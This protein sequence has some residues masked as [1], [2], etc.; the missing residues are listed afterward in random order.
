MTRITSSDHVLLLL[1]E[2]LQRLDRGRAGKTGRTGGAGK[3]TAP[4]M[5]RLQALAALEG[6]S[7]EEFQRSLVRAL[8]SEELGEAV[9]NEPAFQSIVAEIFQVINASPEGRALIE[10]A[11]RE[12]KNPA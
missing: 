3:T 10:R 12:L 1:R 11:A 9:V 7:G 8:L 6:A 4:P 5:E 2:R